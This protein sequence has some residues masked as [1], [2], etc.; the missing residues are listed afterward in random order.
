MPNELEFLPDCFT[1]RTCSVGT[2]RVTYRAFEG[3]PYCA[4]PKSA[5]QVL[6]LFVPEEYYTGASRNGYTLRSAP[7]FMPNTVGGYMEGPADTPGA[8]RSG[9]PNAAFRALQHGYVVACPGIR[10]R[11]TGQSAGESGPADGSLVGRAPALIVDMKAAIR[12]LRHNRAR[13]PGST[14][15]IITS[16]TSAG[17]AL[18]ALAGATGN[19]PAY[20]P[21]LEE[22]GAAQERDDIFAANCY[23]PIHNLENADAAYEWMFYGH[24]EYFRMQLRMTDHGIVPELSVGEMTEKQQH[25]SAELKA[26]FPPYLNSLGLRDRDG[27]PLTLDAD[28]TGRFLEAVQ[29]HVMRAAQAE[30]DT[31]HTA[32]QLAALQVPG[33]EIQRQE[34]LTIRNGKVTAIDWDGY[35]TKLT[36]MKSAP[37][38]DALDLS[39]PE[40]EEFGTASIAARHFT[41]F[42]VSRS[43]RGGQMAEM[44]VIRML[45]PT[46]FSEDRTLAPHWR[47]RHGA[48][49]RDTSLAIPVILA[50]MLENR[51]LDVDFAL[52][53]GLPHCGDYDL[54]ELFAWIDARVRA[55]QQ[56]G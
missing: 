48:F 15:H 17:G 53:W 55:S 47:I 33:S 16:G 38:F 7:I 52:P 27:T 3:I 2:A 32:E 24:N 1:V 37:A 5:V 13:I 25:L 39:S 21:Y 41:D 28:G 19:C 4:R 36:R 45:N 20:A 50:T 8:D 10:G 11:T 44:D 42:S 54:D 43:E 51:G 18:S 49:D 40:N 35:V 12:Y 56:A 26:L 30:L 14:D 31:H 22:I 6:N 34:Y 9:Q 29:A 23:C 46:L